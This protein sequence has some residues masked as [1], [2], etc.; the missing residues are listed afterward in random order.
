MQVKFANKRDVPFL[1]YN[2]RHGAITTIGKMDRGI[3]IFLEQLSSVEVSKDGMT[4]KI[5]GGTNTKALVDALWEAGK[6]TGEFFKQT[7]PLTDET[8][9]T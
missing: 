4:A 8:A 6:Q 2:G 7:A 5:G 1:A 3:E 9:L